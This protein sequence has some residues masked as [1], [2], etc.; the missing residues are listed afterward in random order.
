MSAK[1][2]KINGE[3]LST[4]MISTLVIASV[5]VFNII[6][7]V[8]VE[9]FSLY[10]Y[11]KEEPDFTLSGAMDEVFVSA[12]EEKKKVKISFCSAEDTVKTDSVASYVYNT[13]KNYAER[14]SDVI[15]LDYINIITRRN[16]NG[17]LVDLS[18]FTKDMQ[19][20]DAYI[21]E[22]SVIFECGNNYRVLTDLATTSGYVD[23]FTLNEEGYV[24]SYNGEEVMAGMI[25]WVLADEHKK[26]YFTE[27]HGEVADVSLSN[28]LASAGYFVDIIDLRRNEVP[29]DADLLIISNPTAD[30]EMAA[31]GTG[32]RSEIERI[33]TY[34]ER[35][36][37]LFVS[38]DPYV[39][40]LT[41][42]ESFLSKWGIGFSTSD[43]KR[44]EVK[45]IIKDPYNAITTDGFTV[46]AEYADSPLA[47]L[48]RE[49]TESVSD[50]GIILSTVSALEISG[51]AKPLLYSSSS[52]EL[53][54]NGEP[55][56]S[57]G[58]YCISAY[59]ERDVESGKATVFVIPSV[60]LAVSDTL[61]SRGYSNKEFLYA[62]F[63]EFY[64]AENMPYGCR[65][66]LL[67]TTTL[68]NLKLGTAKIY[69]A[70]IMAVPVA[71]AIVGAVI[72]IKR[73][74]R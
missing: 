60:Y 10:L 70:I 49:K 28:L 14:Y 6:L 64:G 58:T 57:D 42:L 17:E 41:V 29:A 36:G 63:D 71:I 33:E 30:F 74:H 16:K 21:K 31:P 47:N 32:V 38:I 52:A 51:D 18:K 66:I 73:K 55:V 59:S 25:C 44:G 35:G 26:A 12:K 1:K 54:A 5:I 13:A 3:K 48:M 62:L 20:N 2:M 27:K 7:Y 61:V 37:N 9:A 23:F 53:Y 45:N 11:G 65:A 34:L 43:T 46:I 4:S 24:T 19:G 56:N 68:E 40:K 15:E 69:T 22:S 8:L 50:G 67:D 72:I 39:K